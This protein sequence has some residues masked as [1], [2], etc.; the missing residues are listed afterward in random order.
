MIIK[1][2]PNRDLLR[3]YQSVYALLIN[4]S[5]GW[6]ED[7]LCLMHFTKS[8]S[9]NEGLLF[10][11]NSRYL[12]DDVSE[13]RDNRLCIESNKVTKQVFCVLVLC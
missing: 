11:I 6:G 13:F 9:C 10:S 12:R 7:D 2:T 3:V 8:V 1:I 5:K 4:L